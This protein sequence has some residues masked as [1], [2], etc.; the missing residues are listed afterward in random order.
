MSMSDEVFVKEFV[1]RIN[2]PVKLVTQ[3]ELVYIVEQGKSIPL[4]DMW[5]DVEIERLYSG[6][7]VYQDVYKFVRDNQYLFAKEG[8]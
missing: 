1:R 2:R 6:D 5:S 3:K 4:E 7:N 8:K